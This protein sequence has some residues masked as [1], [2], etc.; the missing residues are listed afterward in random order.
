MSL[1]LFARIAERRIEEAMA[2]GE[3]ENLEGAGKPLVFEDDSM[4]PEDLRMA[5]K[6]LRN[7]GFVPPEI[8]EE[9]EILTAADLLAKAPDE[10]ERY[11][12]MNK[13]Q[14]LVMRANMRR[15]RPICLEKNVEY[16]QKVVSRVEIR[17]S[18]DVTD[19]KK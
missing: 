13:L 5:Y 11:R 16:Y 4:V 19:C 18:C 2:R 3:F 15:N 7:S 8:L 10:Q 1:C 9:K 17:G 12:R 6:I 14:V